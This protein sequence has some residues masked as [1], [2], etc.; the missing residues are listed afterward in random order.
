M[1]RK[2]TMFALLIGLLPLAAS[3]LD[4]NDSDL[5]LYFP[6][7]GGGTLSTWTA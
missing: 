6:V 4:I 5:L 1:A 7:N 3:A 2:L